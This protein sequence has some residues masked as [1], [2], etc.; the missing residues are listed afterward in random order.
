MYFQSVVETEEESLRNFQLLKAQPDQNR[1]INSLSKLC[2]WP[3]H[4]DSF[5]LKF[6]F[7]GTETY[8]LNKNQFSIKKACFLAVNANQPYSSFIQSEE[9]VASLALYFNTLFLNQTLGVYTTPED[10][11]LDNP[12]FVHRQAVWFFEPIYVLTPSILSRVWTLKTSLETRILTESELEEHLHGI[13][14]DLFWAYKQEVLRKSETLSAIKRSTRIEL[15]RRLQLAKAFLDDQVTEA[16][17]LDDVAKASMLSKNHLLKHFKQMFQRSPH[18]YLTQRRLE[19]AKN[20]LVH[21]DLPIN[22]IALQTGFED[23]SAFGR[24]FKSSFA[25]TPQQYRE[26]FAKRVIF[27]HS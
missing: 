16:I 4:C 6:V 19:R 18:Q 17:T 3:T 12:N 14:A 5:S 26:Q 2:R 20:S 23:P 25:T 24:L 10:R 1:V 8:C 21:S 27:A 15:Y 13:L 22:R 7:T 9:W 11:L